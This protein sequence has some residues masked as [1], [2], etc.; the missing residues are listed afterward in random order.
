M[1]ARISVRSITEPSQ[2]VVAG[3]V[4][5]GRMPQPQGVR[6]HDRDRRGVLALTGEDVED[7]VGGVDAFAQRLRAGRFDRAEPV[8]GTA[9]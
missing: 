7:D 9:V 4:G 3:A 2:A 5:D 6:G 1:V 8:A